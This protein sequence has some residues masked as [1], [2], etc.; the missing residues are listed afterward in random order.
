MTDPPCSDPP[1]PFVA[2]WIARLSVQLPAPRRALDLAMGRGRHAVPLAAAGFQTFGVDH[3]LDVLV[4]TMKRARARGFTLYAWCA[5]LTR[6][7]LPSRAFQLIVVTRYLQRDLC[8][9]LIDALAPGGFLIY[10]TFT[11]LQKGRGRGP[12]SPDHL[13]KPG[14]LRTLFADLDEIC[15]EELTDPGSDALARL[16]ARKRSSPS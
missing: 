13:L 7:A 3:K 10:E 14:E 6:P 8:P 12:Q 5:D 2:E 15:Y 1:S 16:A 4:D 9:T 11:E